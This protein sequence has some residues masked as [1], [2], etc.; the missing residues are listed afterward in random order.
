MLKNGENK[1]I[2]IGVIIL[3]Q[4][5]AKI[6]VL[7]LHNK[8]LQPK[9]INLHSIPNPIPP[10]LILLGPNTQLKPPNHNHMQLDPNQIDLIA[11]ALKDQLLEFVDE[12]DGGLGGRQVLGAH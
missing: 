7:G 6:T 1:Q 2:Q 11:H 10:M 9:H 4:H 12:L 5:P 3:R 8:Q